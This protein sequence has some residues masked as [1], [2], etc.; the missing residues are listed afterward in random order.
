MQPIDPIDHTY[1]SLDLNGSLV[2]IPLLLPIMKIDNLFE[3]KHGCILIIA[4][5]SNL[6]QAGGFIRTDKLTSS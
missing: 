4:K 2:S 5:A 6:K 3:I 1:H